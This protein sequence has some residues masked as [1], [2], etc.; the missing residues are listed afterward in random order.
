MFTEALKAAI[1]A[2]GMTT[3]ELSKATGYVVQHATVGRFMAGRHHLRL[4]KA[5]ALA[6]ALGIR[7]L[8]PKAKPGRKGRRV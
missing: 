3:W 8:L 6:T 1:K 4:D 7:I 5:D 2:S